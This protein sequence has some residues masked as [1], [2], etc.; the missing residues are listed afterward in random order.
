[1][2]PAA[3]SKKADKRRSK[4]VAFIFIAPKL[5]KTLVHD[6]MKSLKYVKRKKFD[7]ILTIHWL[8]FFI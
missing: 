1:M 8:Y 5:H 6:K 2:L 4:N 7:F 3:F